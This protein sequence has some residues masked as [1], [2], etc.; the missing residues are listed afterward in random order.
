MFSRSAASCYLSIQSIFGFLVF[1]PRSCY[2]CHNISPTQ[3]I[4]GFVS[5]ARRSGM[6]TAA[7]SNTTSFGGVQLC[8]DLDHK[9]APASRC[10]HR[11]ANEV[12]RKDR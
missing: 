2:F 1:S 4:F 3:A 5:E 8:S 12:D 10:G 6:F 9:P 11:Q 7:I